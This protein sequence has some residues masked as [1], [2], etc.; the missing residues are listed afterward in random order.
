MSD[1]PDDPAERL[2]Q[3]ERDLREA[4]ARYRRE[5][6]A[7]RPLVP[8]GVPHGENAPRTFHSFGSWPPLPPKERV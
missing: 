4:K 2:A 1:A 7:M 8:L 6:A 3:A 5:I